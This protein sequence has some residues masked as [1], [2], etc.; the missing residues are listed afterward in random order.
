M[1]GRIEPGDEIAVK[2][3]PSNPAIVVVDPELTPYGY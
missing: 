1:V 2:V 3:D